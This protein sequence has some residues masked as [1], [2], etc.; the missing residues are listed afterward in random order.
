MRPA[1]PPVVTR[2]RALGIHAV[3]AGAAI[4]VGAA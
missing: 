4:Q 1:T 3:L 2:K